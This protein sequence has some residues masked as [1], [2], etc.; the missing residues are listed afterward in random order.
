MS[1]EL[2]LRRARRGLYSTVFVTVVLTI[3]M[4]ICSFVLSTIGWHRRIWAGN[5]VAQRSR[6]GAR[7]PSTDSPASLTF[8]LRLPGEFHPSTR[9]AE[10]TW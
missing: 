3:A 10:A 8:C 6:A 1:P 5:A 7:S 4:A 2:S 9:Q